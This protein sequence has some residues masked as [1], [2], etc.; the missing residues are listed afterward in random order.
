MTVLA[1]GPFTGDRSPSAGSRDWPAARRALAVA[2]VSVI[3]LIAIY[4][5]FVR[6]ATGQR[7]DQLALDHLGDRISSR[8]AVAGW[9]RGVT[10]GVV[11]VVLLG[12]LVVAYVRGRLR[13]GIIA[14]GVVVGANVSTEVLKHLVFSRPHLGHGWA[15]SLPSGHAT[16]VTSLALAALLVSPRSWRG[17]VGVGA[18]VAVTVAGVGTVIANWH[19]PSDVVA[20][21]AVC[22]V[23][24]ALGL[25]AVSLEPAFAPRAESPRAHPFALLTGLAL[26]AAAFLEVGVRPE[27]RTRDLIVHVIVMVGIAIAGAVIVGIFTRMTD[28]RTT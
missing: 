5:V 19:R 24:G 13:L 20:A 26:G 3:A 25:A 6:S 11:A 18:S 10:V 9:L 7:F 8:E 16:V 27:D 15:N 22:L 4:V 1:S 12:C 21:F 2:A 23:W 28:A 17:V 14:V